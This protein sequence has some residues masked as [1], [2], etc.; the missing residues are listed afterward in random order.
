MADKVLA[1]QA[2][3]PEFRFLAPTLKPGRKHTAVTLAFRD[4]DRQ[5]LRAF[6]PASLAETASSRCGERLCFGKYGGDQ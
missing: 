4:G 1:M 3:G 6:C 5:I 2:E